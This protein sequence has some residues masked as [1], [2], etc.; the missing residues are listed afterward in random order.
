V[1]EI[2][3]HSARDKVRYKRSQ[4]TAARRKRSLIVLSAVGAALLVSIAVVIVVLATG[5]SDKYTRVPEIEGLTY[6][7]A[8]AELKK[9]NLDIRVDPTQ[10]VA[11]LKIDKKKVGYQH[12]VKGANAEKGSVVTVALLEVPSK[13]EDAQSKASTAPASTPAAQPEATPAPAPE[14]APAPAPAAPA[15]DSG[16]SAPLEGHPLY[17]LTA[18]GSIACGHWESGSTDYPYF[19]A[20]RNNS[21]KHAGV[22]IYPPAGRGAPVHAL[23]AGTVVKI[24]EYYTRA[25]GEVTYGVVINH[26]DFVANYAEIHPSVSVGQQVGRNQVIGTVGGTVQLHFEQ[27]SAGTTTWVWWY[28]D[29]P[30]NLLDPTALMN[31]LFGM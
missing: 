7:K 2:G 20:P 16:L 12:P 5:G 11:N 14:P 24:G 17:P 27:Y 6:N 3:R 25:D 9:V 23:K 10:D 1:S 8:K 30:G 26:G 15:P 13:G 4:T 19:G 31:Q 22:D 18:D 21:R 29:K 28:G